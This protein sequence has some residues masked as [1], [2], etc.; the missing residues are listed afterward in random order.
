MSQPAKMS[1]IFPTPCTVVAGLADRASGSSAGAARARS[2][3]GSAC[4]RSCP[5]SPTNGRAITRPTAC[6]PVRISR[7]TRQAVVELLERDRLLVRG[8]LED[9]VGRRVDDPLAGPLVLLAELLDDLR[10]RRGLV[11]EHAAPGPVHERVDH[12][13]REAVRV[14]RER[15]SA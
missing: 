8:D 10:A 1:R 9:R 5:G 12:V 2:R 15:L 13:V 7:A 4:A 6:L 14:G 11:A 3:G